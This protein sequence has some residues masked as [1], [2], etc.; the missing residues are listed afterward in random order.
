[1]IDRKKNLN[2]YVSLF[3]LFC[4]FV[5]SFH[6]LVRSL[7]RSLVRP[8][9][10]NLYVFPEKVIGMCQG[11]SVL[12]FNSQQEQEP[13]RPTTEKVCESVCKWAHEDH[14]LN[15]DTVVLVVVVAV[16]VAVALAVAVA[17][18]VVLI[19]CLLYT[20]PSPRD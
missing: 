5:C 1:M 19:V 15:I 11:Y 3:S 14:R 13:P 7:R 20:S 12:G 8:P 10:R 16:A 17:V 6:D 4:Y 2:I 18:A 9:L